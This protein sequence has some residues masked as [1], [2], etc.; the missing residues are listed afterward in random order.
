M[1]MT[2]SETKLPLSQKANL[3]RELSQERTLE[4]VPFRA[5]F[6]NN[7]DFERVVQLARD[8][9]IARTGSRVTTWKVPSLSHAL[10]FARPAPDYWEPRRM[11]ACDLPI[12]ELVL[13]YKRQGKPLNPHFQVF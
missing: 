7:F 11:G 3:W 13:R 4:F 12:Q 1:A 9:Q 2:S 8:S 5:T 6:L 10:V